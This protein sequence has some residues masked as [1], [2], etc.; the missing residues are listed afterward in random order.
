MTEN[1]KLLH[2]MESIQNTFDDQ[3]YFPPT[4][5]AHGDV[6]LVI[7]NDGTELFRSGRSATALFNSFAEWCH[8]NY[9]VNGIVPF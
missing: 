7:G 8:E 9:Q 1:E 6:L 4:F 2:R 3:G 5:E